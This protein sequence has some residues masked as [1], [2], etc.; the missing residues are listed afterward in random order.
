MRP[1]NVRIPF[2]LVLGAVL[3]ASLVIILHQFRRLGELQRRHEADAQALRLLQEALRQKG[4]QQTPPLVTEELPAGND[5]AGIAKREAVIER[6]DKELAEA[7][8]TASDLQA[9]LAAANDQITKSQ[10]SAAE[11][12]QKQQA[13]W[14]AER[15]DLQKKVDTALEQAEIA[16]QRVAALE[17]D[18]AKLRADSTGNSARTADVARTVANLQDLER[19]R[20]GYLTS[21]LR[22]YRDI[23]GEF[24]AMSSMLD[25]SH[26]PNSGA[27]G[28]AVLSRIQ[29]AVTSAEDDMRQLNELSARTQKL[30][31]ELL[32]K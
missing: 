3:V 6:L 4:L 24:R 8:A 14:Q 18:N 5:Q 1:L 20:D 28:G 25:T 30:E 9:Q 2:E 27:C 7:H 23:T 16:H 26:D 32:K 19:R 17:S 31:K 10:A 29:N 15:E 21:I 12:S 11:N 22:R 13:A